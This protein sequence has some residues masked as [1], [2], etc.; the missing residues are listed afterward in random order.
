M[1]FDCLRISWRSF[2]ASACFFLSSFESAARLGVEETNSMRRIRRWA[3]TNL[4]MARSFREWRSCPPPRMRN[5]ARQV[6]RRGGREYQ[7]PESL[8]SVPRLTH[9]SP[10]DESTRDGTRSRSS[11]VGIGRKRS[12]QTDPQS[13][14]SEGEDMK[15][16]RSAG[17]VRLVVLG[18]VLATGTLTPLTPAYSQTQS[19]E[20]RDDR[21]DAR[22]TRQ[23]G[24]KDARDK[25][26]D[27]KA[28]DEKSRAECRQEKRDTKQE[29][30]SQRS[31]APGIYIFGSEAERSLQPGRSLPPRVFL[32]G[33]VV[34]VVEQGPHIE[35]VEFLLLVLVHEVGPDVGQVEI[36]PIA[37]GRHVD[38][39]EVAEPLRM[40]Q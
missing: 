20:R 39:I 18:L 34:G 13:I 12:T 26:A 15:I 40:D 30:V 2:S 9:N 22:D 17:G 29:A 32:A 25:K 36:Q 7:S 38:P 35:G 4:N 3:V 1:S 6:R 24:R 11:R 19:Q 31:G 16:M 10:A 21:Q 27:C 23:T 33:E 28:G 37:R 8:P 14:G 5:V